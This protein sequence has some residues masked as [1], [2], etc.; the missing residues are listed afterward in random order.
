MGAMASA[1]R[2]ASQLVARLAA[3]GGAGVAVGAVLS[4]GRRSPAVRAFGGQTAG[5]GAVDLVIAGVGAA[6]AASGRGRPP[7]A[8][9]LRRVLLVN[10]AL[11]VG[12]VAAGA[13]LVHH[14]PRLGGRVTGAQAAGHG[15]AVVVQGAA[16]LV[17]D[18]AHAAALDA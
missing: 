7:T 2:V 15:W 1:E 12:Y 14:R 6:R 3:L 5:W 11:D 16:L 13:H 4:I 8:S 10:A 17:L 9:R 18:L